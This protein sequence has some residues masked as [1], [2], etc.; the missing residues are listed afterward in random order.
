MW[1]QKYVCPYIYERNIQ[2]FLQTLEVKK[3]YQ[4]SEKNEFLSGIIYRHK[5][6][7]GHYSPQTFHVR[8]PPRW[9]ALTI[10]SPSS[11][12]QMP[13]RIHK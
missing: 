9:S 6:E 12:T 11:L 13:H 7:C 1:N 10:I 8:A 4:K 3:S 2:K 5:L